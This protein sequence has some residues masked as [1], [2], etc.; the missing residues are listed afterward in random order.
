MISKEENDKEVMYFENE[1]PVFS[2]VVLEVDV[3]GEIITEKIIE[4]EKV[5]L[6]ERFH[7]SCYWSELDERLKRNG[8]HAKSFPFVFVLI[9]FISICLVT[10]G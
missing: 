4:P 3:L 8:V 6:K 2:T 1:V 9:V 7:T 5:D 10:I